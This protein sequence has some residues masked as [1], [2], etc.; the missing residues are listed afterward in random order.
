MPQEED[1]LVKLRFPM[2]EMKDCFLKRYPLEQVIMVQN[3]EDDSGR[4]LYLELPRK[5]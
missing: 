2:K 5:M 1:I 4:C 3:F